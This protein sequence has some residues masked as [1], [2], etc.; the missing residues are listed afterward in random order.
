ML[1]A[2]GLSDPGCV[3]PNNEDY[4]IS[5]SACSIFV[6]ADG[7]GGAAGGEFA[8][9]LSAEKLYEYLLEPGHEAADYLEQGFHEA[10]HFVR[11][12]AEVKPELD[13]MATTLVLARALGSPAQSSI[14]VQIGSVG[15][16]RAYYHSRGR[17]QLVTVDQTW[18]AEV[19]SRLGLSEEVLKK[20]HLR[21]VLTMA[22]GIKEDLRVFTTLVEL[23]PGD[24]ILLC[25]DGLHGVLSEK[26][27]L[28]TLNSEQTLPEKCHSLVEAAK[29]AGGPDNITV[30]LIEFD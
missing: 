10:H 23:A 7:M 1:Q 12:A 21:H 26:S 6:L 3:R 22:V 28:E 19:G 4:F 18:V 17:L 20:H 27:L 29:D 11:Q 2:F 14:T 16:S 8:S 30:L 13:G 25:S 15:D 5:D 9:Q 24:Q